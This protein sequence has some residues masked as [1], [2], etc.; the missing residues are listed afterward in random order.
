MVSD[1]KFK[2]Y[3]FNG[4]GRAETIRFLFSYAQ[5]PFE[6]FRFEREQWPSVKPLSPV[7][8]AP[9]IEITEADGTKWSLCQSHTIVRVLGDWFNLSGKNANEKARSDEAY[10][11]LR[12]IQDTMVKAIYEKDEERKKKVLDSL[13]NDCIPRNLGFLEKRASENGGKSISGANS[14]VIYIIYIITR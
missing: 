3:Y 9:F 14:V 5:Q 7:G 13:K 10:E 1:R 11:I 8:Q 4:R 12:D 2:L 6:D